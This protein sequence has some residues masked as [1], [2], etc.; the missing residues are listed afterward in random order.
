MEVDTADEIPLEEQIADTE[1]AIKNLKGLKSTLAKTQIENW[2]ASLNLLKEKQKKAR[3][4]PASLQA[5]T[6]RLSKAKATLEEVDATAA[7]LQEQMAQIL[8]D[9]EEAAAKVAD[10]EAEFRAVQELVAVGSTTTMASNLMSIIA[11]N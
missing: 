11:G 7:E 10:A 9:Q 1:L 2:E 4:L 3:P 8:K 6:A 5:A